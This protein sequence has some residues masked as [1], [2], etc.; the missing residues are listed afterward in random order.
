MVTQ[1]F[2]RLVNAEEKSLVIAKT[3]NV[4][5]CAGMAPLLPVS[6]ARGEGLSV[7]RGPLDA[8]AG[9]FESRHDVVKRLE[10][11]G[12]EVERALLD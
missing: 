2:M 12:F 6:E 5:G 3:V 8:E 4:A 11:A 7:Q 10:T 1:T 9:G